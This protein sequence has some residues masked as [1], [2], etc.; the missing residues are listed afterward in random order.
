MNTRIKDGKIKNEKTENISKNKFMMNLYNNIKKIL[1]NKDIQFNTINER[2]I[3]KSIDNDSEKYFENNISFISKKIKNKIIKNLKYSNSYFF[4][5]NNIIYFSK[6]KEN[7]IPKVITHMFIITKLL[8]ILFNRKDH[9]QKITYFE[10]NEKKKLP[11]K[12]ITLGPNEINSGVTTI[13]HSDNHDNPII[14]FRKEEVIKVLI[15]ELIHSNLI[16]ENIILNYSVHKLLNDNI[17]VNYKIL[18]NEGFT[19]T[20]ATMINMFYINIIDGL[21]NNKLNNMFKNELKYSNDICSKIL[22]YYQIKDI[23]NIIKKNNICQEIFLQKTNIFSYYFIKNILL[24]KHNDLG[25]ILD[26]YTVN[27]K[28]NNDGIL[29]LIKLILNNINEINNR[30]TKINIKNDNNKSLKLCFYEFKI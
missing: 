4:E 16:D 22:N 23:N 27:Y 21:G 30:T 18:L 12:K 9:Y 1:E 10:S 14:L 3:V 5:N 24:F 19:E 28:I 7:K 26:E 20:F 13:H 8:K 11:N 2:I 6:K 15:H 25:K 17:C 29:K